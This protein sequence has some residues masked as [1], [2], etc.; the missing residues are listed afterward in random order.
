[1]SR[2][3]VL[4][5]GILATLSVTPPLATAESLRPDARAARADFEAGVRFVDVRSEAEW[6][7]GHLKGALHLPVGDV[8]EQA[9]QR[10]PDKS[11]PVV[12]YCRSGGRAQAAAMTLRVQ[13]YTQVKA[14]TGGYDDLKSAGYPVVE[15]G[16][17]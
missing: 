5:V 9:A 7:D 4:F 8:A 16:T 14:M 3:L 2:K 10:L 12:T 6:A 17:R 1:M 11:A 15:D 13:G